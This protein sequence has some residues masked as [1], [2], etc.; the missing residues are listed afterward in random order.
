MRRRFA[1]LVLVLAASASALA[2]NPPAAT[3]EEG[4]GPV[5]IDAQ[6]MEGVGQIEMIARGAAQITQDDLVIFGDY[7]KYNRE[8]GWVDARG[9]VRLELGLDRFFGPQ[10]R[11]NTFDDTGEFNDARFLL[12]HESTVHGEAERVDFAGK[13]LYR[14]KKASYTT[15]SPEREDWKV[16]ADELD[17][18]YETEEGKAKNPRLQFFGQ[19]I[20]EAPFAYFPLD[21]ARKSG[22]L[23]P[24]Y[25]HSSTRGIE[26]GI[27]YYWNIAPERDYT[28]TPVY[29]SKRGLM[30]KN[31]ARYI[32]PRYRGEARFEYLPGDQELKRD[33]YGVSWQH[34]QSLGA[35]MGLN[36][37]YNHVSDDRYFIDFASQVRQSSVGN[38]MQDA[39]VTKGGALFA[40]IGYGAMFRVQSF[41]TLQDP[42]APITPPYHRVP[43]IN[44]TASKNDIGG[45]MDS[46]LPLE[47]VRFTHPTLVEGSRFTANP[48]LASPHLAPG[49]FFTPRV[50]LHTVQYGLSNAAPGAPTSPS[51]SIPWLSLD[52]GLVFDRDASWFG[53][54]MVQTLE[55]RLFYVYVPYRN[56][57]AFPVFDTGLA[58]FN[59][60]QLFSENRFGGGDRFGDANQLTAAATSRF[61]EPNGQ[62]I[63]RATVGQRFYFADERVGLPGSTLRTYRHSDYLASIGGR[64]FRH[65]TFDTTVQ[66]NP[67]DNIAERYTISGRYAPEIAKV[68][69]ASYVFNRDPLYPLVKQ[70]DFSGQ[71]PVR[72][73]WYAVGRYN[74]SLLDKRLVNGIAA[75]E[76]NAGCWVLRIAYQRMQA[77]AQIASSAVY[78]QLVLTGAGELGTDEVLTLL[79][80]NVPGYSITNPSDPTL[81]PPSLQR[82]LPFPMVY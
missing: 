77:A 72:T 60:A 7:L 25:G 70:V 79:H 14:M 56:Q 57:D 44:F 8:L 53:Q 41:Q 46:A 64:V 13:D 35:G 51:T 48:T 34:T 33:R 50:G 26:F 3:A 37:D 10:L 74:Y 15:C 24:Y 17:L 20:L 49:W 21:N 28:I 55:P 16:L 1:M 29:M 81:A 6:R 63:F 68:L 36:V 32:D 31:E 40:G 80:R 61:L 4:K 65:A 58:D 23:S 5:T 2:Q 75:L 45:F 19:T 54:N 38:L 43:Q 18:N 22:L 78:V 47:Y 39:Y 59:F 82:P 71:W 52:G 67:R 73:G 27:P 12:P 9:G 66:Y 76:Y 69:S 30:L 11:Y 42:N 62:E